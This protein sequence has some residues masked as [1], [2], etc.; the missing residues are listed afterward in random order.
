MADKTIIKD[1]LVILGDSFTCY[2]YTYANILSESLKMPLHK[3][4]ELGVSNEFILS[5]FH[6]KVAEKNLAFENCIFIFQ[7]TNMGRY[8]IDISENTTGHDYITLHNLWP[9]VH[10][11]KNYVTLGNKTLLLTQFCKN[12]LKLPVETPIDKSIEFFSP[13]Y[14]AVK[15]CYQVNLLADFLKSSGNNKFLFVVGLTRF[16][17]LSLKDYPLTVETVSYNGLGMDQYVKDNNLLDQDMFHP[18]LEG[19]KKIAEEFVIKK[20]RALKWIND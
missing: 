8:E 16:D 10:K 11:N 13:K 7:S 17:T 12:V 9:Y 18:N 15:I 19:H 6:Y 5:N 14:N 2:G 4:A 20:L 1:S 3:F